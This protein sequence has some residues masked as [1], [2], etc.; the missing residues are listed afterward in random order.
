MNH[1][2]YKAEIQLQSLPEKDLSRVQKICA[3]HHFLLSKKSMTRPKATLPIDLG[4]FCN[5]QNINHNQLTKETKAL[6][7]TL[8]VAVG[9]AITHWE[10]SFVVNSKPFESFSVS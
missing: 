10:I 5:S 9:I 7:N 4:W 1:R 2:T 3:E 8:E 6:V